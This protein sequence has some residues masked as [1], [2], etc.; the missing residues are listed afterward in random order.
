MYQDNEN[1][2]PRRGHRAADAVDAE[3][4]APVDASP[5]GNGRVPDPDSEDIVAADLV[6]GDGRVLDPPTGDL[7]TAEV[8]GGPPNGLGR[9]RLVPAEAVDRLRDQWRDAQG[10]FVDDPPG[11]VART[12]TLLTDFVRSMADQLDDRGRRPVPEASTEDL[13]QELR[14]YRA[15]FDQ[16]AEV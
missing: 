9:S 12:R 14:Q 7:P 15:A 5:A 4:G 16:L 8:T 10:M 13:R 11:A 3:N 6:P 1:P 2:D